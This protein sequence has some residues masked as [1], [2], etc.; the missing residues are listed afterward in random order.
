MTEKEKH[1]ANLLE[2]DY[3]PPKNDA[4]V[5]NA[6]IRVLDKV[7]LGKKWMF[8]AITRGRM[9]LHDGN[10]EQFLFSILK[11]ASLKASIKMEWR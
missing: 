7:F 6:N 9:H 11:K 10:D 8:N 2:N 3:Q 5:K 1:P 4:V